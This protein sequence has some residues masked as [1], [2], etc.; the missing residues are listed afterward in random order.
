MT[1]SHTFSGVSSISLPSASTGESSSLTLRDIQ[2]FIRMRWRWIV[3]TTSTFL[4]V[5]VIYVLTA[6]PTYIAT[7]QLFVSPQQNGSEAQ[8]AFA[9]DAF[10]EAQ[11]EIARSNDVFGETAKTLDLTNDPDFSRKAPSLL[12]TAKDWLTRSL[13]DDAEPAAV[14]TNKSDRVIARLKNHVA[15]RQIGRST[16]LEIS[17]SASS[18]KKAVAIADTVARQYIQK[19]V[20]MKAQAA[21]KY[22]DWLEK[23]LVEQQRGLTDAANDLADFKSNPR[24]Q[25]K[26]AE[27]QSAA[28]ARR[29]LYENTLTQYSEAKQRISDPV[30]DATIVSPATSPLSKA[31]P[32]AAL[33]VG[34]ATVL[35]ASAGVMLGMVRH[36]GDRRIIR[37]QRFA[38]AAGLPFVTSLAK[39]GKTRKRRSGGSL[40]AEAGSGSAITYPFIPGMAELSATMVGLRRKRKV[41]VIGIVAIDPKSGASTIA[42]ELAV[43]C[44]ES[45]SQTLLIDADAEK[46]SLSNSIAPHSTIGLADVLDDAEL[47]QD[48]VLSVRPTL[49]FLPIGRV[50]GVTPAIRLSSRRTQLNFNS[51]KMDYDVVFVDISPFAVSADANAIAPELD[52]VLVVTWH[53]RTSIDEAVRAIDSL[54]NVGAEVLGA[55][56]NKAPLR[57]QS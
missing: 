13:T 40:A 25:F 52:G 31:R 18:P 43:L 17:A 7:T 51:L 21:R 23:F 1:S 22:S 44:A 9:E 16:I 39:Y 36:A 32:R 26:L 20:L 24:D 42:C 30:S 55:V 5:A 48:A 19:N 49:R 38:D 50:Q 57:M 56:V 33:I 34:F 10:L 53:G 47:I 54:R 12:D 8:K 2:F 37:V 41:V 3:V 11:L 15:M 6:Q 4:V 14:A 35:G 27:L 45:G 29:A 46:S 28:A